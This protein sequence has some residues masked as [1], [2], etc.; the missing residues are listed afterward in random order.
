MGKAASKLSREDITTLKKSTYFDRRELQQWYKG[1]KRDCPSGELS[2]EEFVKIYKQFFPF[3]DP[4]EFSNYVFRV[5]DTDGDGSIDFKEFII[6]LSIT[7]RGTLEE[8]LIWAFQL[9]DLDDDGKITYDEMLSIVKSMY[10]MIGSMVEL[11]EDEK[12][13]E[14]RVDKLF[15]LFDKN[16]DSYISFEEFKEG[17]KIDPSIVEALNLYSGLV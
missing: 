2:K 8:K 3:G 4:T 10:K 1:F 7:S 15:K 14:Q 17:S 6:L 11:D 16:H 5:F 13:P 12:T 9:Y